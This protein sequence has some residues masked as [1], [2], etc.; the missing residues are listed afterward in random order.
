MPSTDTPSADAPA[1]P[2]VVISGSSMPQGALSPN[3]TPLDSQQLSPEIVGSGPGNGG[4]GGRGGEPRPTFSVMTSSSVGTILPSTTHVVQDPSVPLEATHQEVIT[5][6]DM[7]AL[8]PITLVGVAGEAGLPFTLRRDEVAT[9]AKLVIDFG[10]SPALIPELSHLAIQ[11]NG[12]L[13]GSIQLVKERSGGVRVEIP[14]NPALILTENTLNIRFIGHYTW[15]CEDPLHSSLWAKISNVQSRVELTMQ[16]LPLMDDLALLPVPFFDKGDMHSLSLPFVFAG[17]PSDGT[18]QAAA[19]VASYFGLR[20]SYRG[21]DFPVLYG[22]I[23]PRNAVVFATAADQIPGL[24]LPNIT[25]PTVAMVTNP[26]NAWGKLL[27]VLGRNADELRAAAY[28][29]SVGSTA[30][31]GAVQSVGNPSLDPRV[32][33]D[34]V[35]WLRT[36]KPVRFGDIAPPLSLQGIGL[37]PGPLTLNYRAAPDTFVWPDNGIPVNLRYRFPNGE[38]LDRRIS[39][40][41]I[42]QN[43]KYLQ[44]VPLRE[45]KTVDEVR[46]LINADYVLNSVDMKLPPYL[47]VGQNQMQFYYD[48]RVNKRGECQSE[49]PGNVRTGIDPDSTIDLTGT[50]HFTQLPNLAYFA[51]A[52]FPFTRMADLSETDVVLQQQPAPEEISAFLGLMGRMGD[53]TGVPVTGVSLWRGGDVNLLSG[54][55][56]LVIG[57]LQ[58]MAQFGS[59]MEGGPFAVQDGRLRVGVNSI[60]DRIFSMFGTKVSDHEGPLQADKVLVQANDFSGMLSFRSPLSSDRVIVGVLSNDVSRLPR[61]VKDLEDPKKGAN[62]QGDLAINDSADVSSYRVGSVFWEG[63]LSWLTQLRW[64]LSQNPLLLFLGVVI[65]AIL[66]ATPIYLA[67]RGLARLRLRRRGRE[68]P[69][70]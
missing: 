31:T 1:A 58:M 38:W 15:R 69:H 41:D 49:V 53:A 13:I 2:G 19:S 10:Y 14:I 61:I 24:A 46:S 54:K 4:D 29:L 22:S 35:R 39:R 51:T 6:E 5:F 70:A 48:L 50:K 30:M 9:A 42:S 16:R 40:L 57:P 37:P 7:G 68:E 32:P 11:L 66:L 63:N 45:E 47:M 55:D 12:E 21:F 27:L 62:V 23:P 25:G 28:T 43:G 52:G 56:I 18:L 26:F 67:L 20:S 44:S 17:S 65:A 36:D 64:Y 8:N 34:A 60:I 59:L 3:G 33:Y